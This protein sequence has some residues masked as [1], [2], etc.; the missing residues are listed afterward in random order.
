MHLDWVLASL[1]DP[2]TGA[3]ITDASVSVGVG[4]ASVTMPAL[5][6]GTLAPAYFVQ[7]GSPPQAQPTYVVTAN[8]AAFDAGSISATLVASIDTIDAAPPVVDAGNAGLTVSWQEDPQADYEV[9]DLFAAMGDAGWVSTPVFTSPA[10]LP[11]DQTSEQVPAL[12]AGS[13]LV[14]VSYTKANCVPDAG[15]VQAATVAATTVT[16]N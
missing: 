8:S 12:D 5:D 9:V 14:N 11:P 4:D 1:L 10:G 7:F 2:A 3:P 16:I 6:G 13:Y 15:C